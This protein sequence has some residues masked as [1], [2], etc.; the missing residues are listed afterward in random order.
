MAS[1]YSYRSH[2]IALSLILLFS[3]LCTQL[4]LFNYV[5]FEFSALL[6]LV[7]SL[8]VGLLTLSWWKKKRE[9][10]EGRVWKFIASLIAPIGL[11][12]VL[13][14]LILSLNAFFVKNCSFV[15][16]ILLYLLLPVP[17]FAFASSLALVIATSIKKWRKTWFV[18]IW[19]VVLLH[20]VVVTVL[21]PQIFAFNPIVGYFP[22]FTYDETL[23]IIDRLLIYR[24]GT[25]LASI[26]LL[27]FAAARQRAQQHSPGKSALGFLRYREA[28]AGIFLLLPVALLYFSS[29]NIGLSS[30]VDHIREALGGTVETEHF[31]IHYPDTVL[32]GRELDHLVQTHEFY[33][34]HIARFYRIEPQTKIVV[35]LYAS[36]DQKGRLVGAKGTNFAKPWLAQVHLNLA[37]V[38]RSLKH[39]LVHVLAAEFG[40]PVLRIGMNA[41]LIEGAAVAVEQ[42]EYDEHI[43]RLAAMVLAVGIEPDLES[44]FSFSGFMK[45]HPSISY[46]LV[47][48][49]SRFLIERFGIR[50][51]KL[52]YQT[53]DFETFYNR[54]LH[55]LL[56]QWRRMV[57]RYELND[58]DLAK[59]AYLFKRPSIFAKE[60]ARVLANLNSETR[61]QLRRREFDVALARAARALELSNNIEATHLK[62]QALV[63]LGRFDEA[64]EFMEDRLR[65]SSVA[66]SLLPLKLLL[67]DAYLAIDSLFQAQRLYQHISLTRLS[68]AYDE[69]S[70]LRLEL[71]FGR[72]RQSELRQVFIGNLVDTAR[73]ALIEQMVERHTIEALP[74]YLLAREVAV[75]QPER[76]IGLL[77][78]IRRM[79]F[80][81]LEFHRQRRL[82]RLNFQLGRYERAKIHAWQSL[83]LVTGTAQVLEIEE[84]LRL[85][86]WMRERLDASE[87]E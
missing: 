9:E 18:L 21:G 11:L 17:A 67:G 19:S 59:A 6:S 14:L 1:F 43:H 51:F 49:F 24:G 22:G 27:L 73:L 39:E 81:Q 40:L 65:D 69:A 76:A 45:V 71:L 16:G 64:I 87:R 46:V 38:D 23:E 53:G 34:D 62:A 13:P 80:D 68:S 42:A 74:K 8:I 61:E 20:I 63:R 3:L 66:H 29:S 41:G 79:R 57:E 54:P 70:T 26:A 50:R 75:T 31:R 58:A 4:P 12:L 78:S 82:A 86:D 85:C 55:E 77:E 72:L 35:F 44:L 37:D 2:R 56:A 30:S 25:L 15:Q 36:A 7:G 5:G 48:S 33:F 52:L 84:M 60:C 47:G 32:R 83:N 28:R 10:F